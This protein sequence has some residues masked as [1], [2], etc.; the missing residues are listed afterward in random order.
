MKAIYKVINAKGKVL[1]DTHNNHAACFASYN[2]HS[3]TYNGTNTVEISIPKGGSEPGTPLS[4][5]KVRDHIVELSN[6]GFPCLLK[7]NA[8]GYTVV[9]KESDCLNKS[10]MRVTIDYVRLLWEGHVTIEHYY[11]LPVA[12]RQHYDYFLTLQAMAI[13]VR[14]GGHSIASVNY[15]CV[16]PAKRILDHLRMNR[17]HCK[18][19]HTVYYD[20]QA[21]C[22]REY[23]PFM[24]L[25]AETY[26]TQKMPKKLVVLP[27]FKPQFQPKNGI[28][29]TVRKIIRRKSPVPAMA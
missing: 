22:K 12:F 11:R 7:E 10:H 28:A 6:S 13:Q 16:I 5:E 24:A 3:S 9:I 25:V 21:A 14:P 17:S 18:G 19:T 27:E 4:Y 8:T 23:A 2:L 20:L 29:S 1:I 15:Q 26:R